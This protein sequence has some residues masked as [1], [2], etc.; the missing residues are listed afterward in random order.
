MRAR[1]LALSINQSSSIDSASLSPLLGQL[2]PDGFYGP[3]VSDGLLI[4]GGRRTADYH[5]LVH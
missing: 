5:V 3:E 4:G 2:L 1:L